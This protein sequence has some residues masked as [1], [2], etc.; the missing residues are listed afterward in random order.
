MKVLLVN[1]FIRGSVSQEETFWSVLA[2]KLE[3]ASTIEIQSFKGNLKNEIAKIN[4]DVLIYNS[5]LGKLETPEQ[6]KKIVILQ[7]NFVKMDKVLPKSWKQKIKKALTGQ[8]FYPTMIQRQKEAIASADKV[9]AVSKSV[10]NSYGV[11]AE[12]IPIGV[13]EGLFKPLDSKNDLRKEYG[14]PIDKQVY[15]FVGSQHSVKGFDLLQKEIKNNPDKFYIVV[16]KDEIPQIKCQN[17]KYFNKIS[18]EELCKLYNCAD[19]YI[20]F[21]RVE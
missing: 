18:Q 10:A 5:V 4:P 20:G 21:S 8:N 7:D 9:V 12:I 6:S 3:N 14:I 15:I 2:D 13:N 17:A 16:L 1:N 19:G 11:S